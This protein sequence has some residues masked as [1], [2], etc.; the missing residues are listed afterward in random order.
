MS[1]NAGQISPV[2]AIAMETDIMLASPV[3]QVCVGR[4]LTSL[5][6]TFLYYW[7]NRRTK[8]VLE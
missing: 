3:I 5:H 1:C 6:F 2:C 4:P 7:R 8:C